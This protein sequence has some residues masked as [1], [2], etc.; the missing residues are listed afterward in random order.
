MLSILMAS[1][2]SVYADTIKVYLCDYSDVTMTNKMLGSV[3]DALNPKVIKRK[4]LKFDVK[5]VIINDRT[6]VPIRVI[7]EELGYEVDWDAATQSV[8]LSNVINTS[9]N[10]YTKIIQHKRIVDL[11]KDL[12]TASTQRKFTK[13]RNIR[14]YSSTGDVDYILK[15]YPHLKTDIRMYVGKNT[16][17]WGII[18][19]SSKGALSSASASIPI[20]SIHTGDCSPEIVDGRTLVPLRTVSEL[21]GLDIQWNE[22]TRTITMSGKVLN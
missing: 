11:F 4:E 1:S 21:L 6:Y 14:V 19:V 15:N 2:I 3:T 17:Q 7:A 18:P 9:S 10:L 12:E 5:P 20:T 8:I 22:T 16:S 13:L